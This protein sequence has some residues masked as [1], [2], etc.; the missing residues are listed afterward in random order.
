MQ[1]LVMSISDHERELEVAVDS[2][3]LVHQPMEMLIM[4]ATLS[5]T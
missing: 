1:R 4:M 2:N 5:L 3:K